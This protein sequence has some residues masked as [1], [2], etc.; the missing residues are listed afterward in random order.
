MNK[1]HFFIYITKEGE[2]YHLRIDYSDLLYVQA[3]GDYIKIY[4]KKDYY[5]VHQSLG[6]I[7]EKLKHILY[8]NHR[9]YSVN[10]YNIDIVNKHD[11]LIGKFEIPIGEQYKRGLLEILYKQDQA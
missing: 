5:V 9:S 6:E 7:T 10:I 2:G 3:M 11:I 4:T 1:D 8:R